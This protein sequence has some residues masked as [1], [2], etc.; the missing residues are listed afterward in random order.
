[1]ERL[2]LWLIDYSNTVL[3]VGHYFRYIYTT[4]LW[5][6]A[7]CS[8]VGIGRRLRGA[9]CLH[10]HGDEP[11]IALKMEAV[12]TSKKSVNI[13]KTTQRNIPEDS[14]LICPLVSLRT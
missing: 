14:C 4:A 11:L 13:Y 12:S 6:V 5:D 3:D 2:C 8:Q 10:D 1:L 7:P 9:Y